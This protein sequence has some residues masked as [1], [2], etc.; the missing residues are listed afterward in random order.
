MVFK[1]EAQLKA[2]LMPKIKAAVADSEN[3][4]YETINSNVDIFYGEFTPKIYDRVDKLSNALSATEVM[5]IGS[6]AYAEVWFDAG[7]MDYTTGTW[8]GET[9]LNV[10][11]NSTVPHGGYAPGTAIWSESVIDL[12]DTEEKMAQALRAQ[13]IPI[14][15]G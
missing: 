8:S 4:V 12:I 3:E 1:N 7:L 10:A 2:F 9:V 13:G 6:G 15:K 14:V 11:M 5:Q